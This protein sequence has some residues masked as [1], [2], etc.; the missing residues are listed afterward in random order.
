[1]YSEPNAADNSNNL[2]GQPVDVDDVKAPTAPKDDIDL[3]TEWLNDGYRKGRVQFIEATNQAETLSTKTDI[4]R[5]GFISLR[6]RQELDPW[7]AKVISIIDMAKS[8]EL[9]QAYDELQRQAKENKLKK[10]PSDIVKAQANEI[11]APLNRVYK[12]LTDTQDLLNKTLSWC[13]SLQ[14]IIASDEFGE[15]YSAAHDVPEDFFKDSTKPSSLS[16]SVKRTR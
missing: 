3:L 16:D 5:L 12:E 4:V 2:S 14:K 6:F 9:V 1:M 7:V 10:P 8:T 15:L 13:Q 11:I